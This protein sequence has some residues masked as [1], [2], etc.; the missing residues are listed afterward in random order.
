MKVSKG[1]IEALARQI[2]P[3]NEANYVLA[4]REYFRRRPVNI[5]SSSGMSNEA[6][7]EWIKSI[8]EPVNETEVV[9]QDY[10]IRAKDFEQLQ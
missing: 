10:L 6:F 7:Y 9:W 2:A 4:L 1:D 3:H 5:L 8:I